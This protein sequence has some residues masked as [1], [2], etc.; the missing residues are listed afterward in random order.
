VVKIAVNLGIDTTID[1]TPLKRPMNFALKGCKQLDL[2]RLMTILYVAFSVVVI[3]S[4]PN[5]ALAET[6]ANTPR[7]T[8]LI[9]SDDSSGQS[10]Q[11]KNE[12]LS[13]ALTAIN[14][15]HEQLVRLFGQTPAA[16][17]VIQLLA[18]EEFAKRTNAPSWTS[19]MYF[20]GS[21]IVPLKKDTQQ[22]DLARTLKHEYV[23][24]FVAEV[25]A[26]RCPAWLDEG[27][28]QVIEGNPNPTIGPAL[29]TWL[30]GNKAMP[31]DWLE[32]GFVT[33]NPEIVPTAYGQSMFATK[34][35]IRTNGFSAIRKYLDS[36]YRGENEANAFSSAFSRSKPDFEKQL[37]L[38][39]GLWAKSPIESP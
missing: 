38:Q 33:L 29:R 39:L 7:A 20:R 14:Q 4:V 31:L 19:A 10:L 18:P 1:N 21:I 17:A 23:H 30:A 5:V 24:Y 22:R 12:L 9:P 2:K 13:S 6:D 16:K 15:T 28:A 8:L 26:N 36:L 37:D 35:L 3:A 27:I 32:E 11:L 34:T 25:S